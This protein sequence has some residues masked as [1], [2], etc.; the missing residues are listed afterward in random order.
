MSLSGEPLS[1]GF[2]RTF[3]NHHAIKRPETPSVGKEFISRFGEDEAPP[4]ETEELVI[5]KQANRFRLT[6]GPAFVPRFVPIALTTKEQLASSERFEAAQDDGQKTEEVQYGLQQSR[7][8]L[9]SDATDLE[10][11]HEKTAGGNVDADKE[12]LE[13]FRA[14]IEALPDEA[15]ASA[16]ERMP[17][18]AFG[19]AMLKGMDWKE[20]EVLGKNKDKKPVDAVEF[21]P[22]ASRLGLGAAPNHPAKKKRGPAMVLPMGADGK[23]RHVRTLDEK[24]VPYEEAGI[25]VGDKRKITSGQ[26]KGFPCVVVQSPNNEGA[27]ATD[28]VIDEI[29]RR[30]R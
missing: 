8:G 26:H 11:V 23:V 1:F 25:R 27:V 5:P 9:L 7:Q 4:R 15:D 12:S 10:F 16:Y 17:V 2:K 13:A 20:G 24:L 28:V 30:F 6:G 29:R 18:E 21:V 19:L 14:E 22:R 3:K